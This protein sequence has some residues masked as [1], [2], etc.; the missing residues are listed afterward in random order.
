MTPNVQRETFIALRA[1]REAYHVAADVLYEAP[2]DV[3]T[4]ACR[5][6]GAWLDVHGS[7]VTDPLTCPACGALTPLPP[8][9][10]ARY[11]P[12]LAE[13]SHDQLPRNPLGYAALQ[14]PA[15]PSVNWTTAVEPS[16]GIPWW[17]L[18]FTA[19][20][21]TILSGVVVALLTR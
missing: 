5:G 14:D 18:C 9:L 13:V 4:V 8:Y 21:L 19:T 6:C 10:R 7:T 12:R 1:R 15:D 2:I 20:L 11:L 16:W 17:L 3:R